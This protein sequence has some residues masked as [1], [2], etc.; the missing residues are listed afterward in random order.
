MALPLRKMHQ[1]FLQQ[2]EWT[3]EL[4][5]HLF[6]RNA[7]RGSKRVLEVGSG[8]GV[9]LS[10]IAREEGQ[11]LHGLDIHIPSLRKIG[12]QGIDTE[13]ALLLFRAMTLEA[14]FFQDWLNLISKGVDIRL[15]LSRKLDNRFPIPIA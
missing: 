4:R 12:I 2:A 7:Y 9:V 14:G 10:Q 5:N 1:R 11:T 15:R 6:E 8:T 13:I 3:A